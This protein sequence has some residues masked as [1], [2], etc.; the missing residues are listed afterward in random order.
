MFRYNVF[1]GYKIVYRDE[2]AVC[3]LQEAFNTLLDVMESNFAAL[4][5]PDE[6]QLLARKNKIN[7][8]NRIVIVSSP[9]NNN[10]SLRV[11]R[12]I[13]NPR[14]REISGVLEIVFPI[15]VNPWPD[16]RTSIMK[17]VK[18]LEDDHTHEPMEIE[19]I[20]LPETP[21]DVQ[22]PF[23][24]EEDKDDDENSARSSVDS[25]PKT[26]LRESKL[27]KIFE[28]PEIPVDNEAA[29]SEIQK[30]KSKLRPL[31]KKE[32][33]EDK[34][35]EASGFYYF[36]QMMFFILFPI[37]IVV[38]CVSITRDEYDANKC[39]SFNPKVA[40]RDLENRLFGQTR[41]IKDLRSHL[42]TN[43]DRFKVL[44]LIGGA[45]VGKSY[46]AHIIGENFHPKKNVFQ[47]VPPLEERRR[48]AADAVSG[49]GCNLIILENLGNKDISEAANLVEYLSGRI[50]DK[51]CAIVIQVINVQ[52]TDKNL[53]RDVNL[54]KSNEEIESIYKEKKLDVKIVR[55][56]P[57]D[58]NVLDKCIIDAANSRNIT[59]SKSDIDE[60][61]LSLKNADTGCKGARAK[62]QLLDN[63]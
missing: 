48:Y 38:V 13:K 5:L 26:I 18:S 51:Y 41:A 35:A 17:H 39:A 7:Q 23:F 44:A 9:S 31:V 16:H 34:R 54:S 32:K 57:L 6:D 56:E 33:K 22:E 63:N 62:V 12:I 30:M 4:T 37:A 47:Y 24:R 11:S 15:L 45:G 43:F 49:C 53:R 52:E 14:S 20:I 59:L 58:D 1:I 19:E 61:R 21:T 60:V 40:I 42:S 27:A 36:W 55:F 46:A 28:A 50:A 8:E 3:L 2:S 10:I 25:R 29:I